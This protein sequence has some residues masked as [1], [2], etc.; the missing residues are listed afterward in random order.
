MEN[1]DDHVTNNKFCSKTINNHS[2]RLEKL[3]FRTL[4]KIPN[5]I[6]IL[7]LGLK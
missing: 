5:S 1:Y 7:R 4:Q 6:L 2:F 3:L